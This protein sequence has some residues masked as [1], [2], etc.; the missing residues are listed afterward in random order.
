MIDSKSPDSWRIIISAD[1]IL[2]F[3]V[4]IGCI[5]GLIDKEKYKGKEILWPSKSLDT[6]AN[7]ERWEEWFKE[8]V[9]LKADKIKLRN[10]I[11]SIYEEYMPPEFSKVKCPI[12]KE[13]CKNSWLKFYEWWSMMAGGKNAISF[14][15]KIGHYKIRK[16]VYEVESAL[17]RKLKPFTLNIELLY[18]GISEVIDINNEFIITPLSPIITLD[19]EWWIK[20]LSE[21]G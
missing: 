8:V 12:L 9:A 6:E 18:T 21:I 7:S 10:Q 3:I 2:N 1:D 15:E 11:T 4:Y 16:Y 14:L 17:G 20:K 5:Y 13:C 19:K